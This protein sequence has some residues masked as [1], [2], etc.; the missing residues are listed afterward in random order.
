MSLDCPKCKHELA[1]GQKFCDNCGTQNIEVKIRTKEEIESM[2][3]KLLSLIGKYS[4]EKGLVAMAVVTPQIVLLGWVLGND[5]DP[6][7]ALT[8]AL[9]KSL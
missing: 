4:G 2:Q 3:E 5:H 8:N 7:S 1:P 9:N 6:T